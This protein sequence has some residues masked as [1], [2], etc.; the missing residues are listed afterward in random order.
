VGEQMKKQYGSNIGK[1]DGIMPYSGYV[2]IKESKEIVIPV[3]D[4]I[5]SPEDFLESV[6]LIETATEQDSIILKV[7]CEGGS[8]AAIDYLLD[9]L[10]KTEATAYLE[11]TGRMCSAAT[12]LPDHVDAF[13][14]SDNCEILIHNAM[15]GTG[16]KHKDVLD[17][18]MFSEKMNRKLLDR[19]YAG[20]FTE[21]EM[22]ELYK[23]R[24][25][26]MD[27]VEYLD[28]FNRRQNYLEQ[29]ALEA[30]N[31]VKPP[32]KKPRKKAETQEA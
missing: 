16:G 28:R 25:F 23:G 18:V 29:V 5:E 30:A 27:N 22:E 17:Y 6:Y 32:V 31:N 15:F 3:T 26:H 19:Y 8:L 11:A 2:R 7:N 4:V 24:Q 21:E 12:F 14:I 1:I 10:N 20:M 13:T 9:A